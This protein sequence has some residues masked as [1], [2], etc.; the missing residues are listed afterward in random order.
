MTDL[1]HREVILDSWTVVSSYLLWWVKVLHFVQKLKTMSIGKTYEADKPGCTKSNTSKHHGLGTSWWGMS[2]AEV[3]PLCFLQTNVAAA[4]YK[5]VLEH[6][7]LLMAEQLFGG[8]EFTFQ[9]NLTPTHNGKSTKTKTISGLPYMGYRS[10]SLG[11]KTFRI[12]IPLK[13]F[14]ELQR[15]RWLLFFVDQLFW[16]S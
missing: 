13:I 5:E 16:S 3:G 14:G 4:V 8:Y 10:S 15:R 12:S 11:W 1:C 9:P 6:F 7:L 2:A